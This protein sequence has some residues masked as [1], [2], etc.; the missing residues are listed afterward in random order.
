[1]QLNA[2]LFDFSK[3]QT[4]MIFHRENQQ[5]LAAKCFLTAN[6]KGLAKDYK[7]GLQP[8]EPSQ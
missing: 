7:R 3:S 2:C 4:P 8:T 6:A 1:L 5:S